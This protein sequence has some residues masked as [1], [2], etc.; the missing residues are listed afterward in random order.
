MCVLFSMCACQTEPE[1]NALLKHNVAEIDYILVEKAQ[2]RLS[3][4]HKDDL[5]KSYN[6][7]LGRN[8]IGHKEREGDFKTPEGIYKISKKNPKSKYHRSLKISYPNSQDHQNAKKKG[9]HPG[10]DIMIH[11]FEPH[12]WWV[13]PKHKLRDLTRGCIALTNQEIEEIFNLTPVGTTVEITP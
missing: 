13:S 8:P 10:G 2:H 1:D 6:I 3:L 7:A 5:V 9:H 4:F 11:G 12:Y